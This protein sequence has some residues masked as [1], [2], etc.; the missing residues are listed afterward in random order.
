MI[1]GNCDSLQAKKNMLEM[2]GLSYIPQF[3]SGVF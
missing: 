1:P 3:G 2:F